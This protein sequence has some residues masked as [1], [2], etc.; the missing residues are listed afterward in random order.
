MV[1]LAREVRMEDVRRQASGVEDFDEVADGDPGGFV[2][3]GGL[4]FGDVEASVDE[5]LAVVDDAAFALQVGQDFGGG[6]ALGGHEGVEG[7]AP[8]LAGEMPGVPRDADIRFLKRHG[9]QR[10]VDVRRDEI[11]EPLLVDPF[12]RAGFPRLGI[13]P[14]KEDGGGV[15]L[16][17]GPFQEDAHGGCG[18]QPAGLAA[19]GMGVLDVIVAQ[20]F[21]SE[22][23][24]VETGGM[25][26]LGTE[27]A[28]AE[29][30]VFVDEEMGAGGPALA[31]CGFRAAVKIL[32]V[33]DVLDG[34]SSGALREGWGG[35]VMDRDAVQPVGHGTT[36]DVLREGGWGPDFA[37]VVECHG[38]GFRG[39][40][41]S[42]GPCGGQEGELEMEGCCL[43]R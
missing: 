21:D 41:I 31:A 22:R 13:V 40:V 42:D 38:R 16:E 34:E 23:A 33:A 32:D 28:H 26:A 15:F 39:V 6:H 12:T 9:V 4:A 35:R 5:F 25:D 7:H 2:G 18:V 8:L 1:V 29:D 11:E 14:V 20:D 3:L 37:N 19:A 36:C 30:L 43:R 17:A 10:P 27:I 24:M